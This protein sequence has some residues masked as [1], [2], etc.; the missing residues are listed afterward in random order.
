MDR[1][2]C[3][4]CHEVADTGASELMDRWQLHPVRL[5]STWFPE[6]RFNHAS[7]RNLEGDPEANCLGCHSAKTS[8]VATDVLIPNEDNC[9]GCHDQNTANAAIDCVSC[10]GFHREAG[11]K[12]VLVREVT[13]ALH[14]DRE[15]LPLSAGKN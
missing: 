8:E 15:Q 1:R 13:H 7:H 9:L 11:D 5:V 14:T 12:S 4:T 2:M 10:H 3:I 6:A